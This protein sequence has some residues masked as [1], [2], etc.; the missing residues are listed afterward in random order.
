MLIVK[1]IWSQM[2]IHC[3]MYWNNRTKYMATT[4]AAAAIAAAKKA[5]QQQGT[6]VPYN[7]LPSEEKKQNK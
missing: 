4:P 5:A 3:S 2:P 6:D 7:H 1:E